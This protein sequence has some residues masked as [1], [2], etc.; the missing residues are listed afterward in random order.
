MLVKEISTK[1]DL[2]K[3]DRLQRELRTLT[4][5]SDTC[6]A[7]VAL[8]EA[9]RAEII[10]NKRSADYVVQSEG[11]GTRV[12]LTVNVSHVAVANMEKRIIVQSFPLATMPSEWKRQRYFNKRIVKEELFKLCTDSFLAIS[13]NLNISYKALTIPKMAVEMAIANG[14]DITHYNEEAEHKRHTL[15]VMMPDKSRIVVDCM[16]TAWIGRK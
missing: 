14:G 6:H 11:T 10:S 9:V 16:E 4:T 12:S 13:A 5:H 7:T 8:A 2:D 3:R 1:D 15:S